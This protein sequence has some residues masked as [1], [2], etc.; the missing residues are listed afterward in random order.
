[1]ETAN[2][3]LPSVGAYTASARARACDRGA[4]RKV[5]EPSTRA[6][7]RAIDGVPDVRKTRECLACL[8]KHM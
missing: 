2:V 1:M 6:R 4:R 7:G 5:V 3:R 8:R